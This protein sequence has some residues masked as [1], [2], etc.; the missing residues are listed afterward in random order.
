MPKPSK[1]PITIVVKNGRWIAYGLPTVRTEFLK[2][3]LLE[4]GGVNVVVP[5]GTYYYNVKGSKGE[6]K[7]A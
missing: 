1:G 3:K 4:A 7:P 2:K 5:D 6:L